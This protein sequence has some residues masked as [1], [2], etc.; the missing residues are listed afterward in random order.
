MIFPQLYLGFCWEGLLEG[1]SLCG[2]AQMDP[3][4]RFEEDGDVGRY[5]AL[6]Q[7][8]DLVV[9]HRSVPELLPELALRL[10]TVASFEIA[11][12]CLHDPQK[13]VM[14]VHFWEGGER[15]S[16]LAEL[17]VE[18]S[19]CGFVWEKQRPIVLPDLRVETR[20]QRAVTLLKGKGVRSYCE[21]PLT[22]APMHMA[23]TML[24]FCAELPNWWHW[25]WKTR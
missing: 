6:L 19:A 2:L 1:A 25:R 16:D 17:P 20:F 3:S 22:T 23:T 21:L 4:R 18:E 5:E 15:P 13:N 7:M 8:A 11:S 12:L 14:R 10:R 9:H 24:S